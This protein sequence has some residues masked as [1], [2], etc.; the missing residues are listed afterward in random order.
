MK[1]T[2]KREETKHPLLTID[3][4]FTPVSG[5]DGDEFYPNGIFVFN[6]TKM[7]DYIRG[8]QAQIFS[9]SIDVRAHRSSFSHLNDDHIE[10]T[11]ISI[12]IILAE[13][14]PGRFNVIDGNHRI[15]KAYRSDVDT[16]LAYKL[17][18]DQHIR[19]LTTTEAYHAYV[20]YWNS[21]VNG[22]NPYRRKKVHHKL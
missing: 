6:I 14:S 19:F 7:I 4:N 1:R 13:I 16:I 9:E 17:R 5:D 12:P 2:L 3:N 11:D 10:K 15:E 18:P 20:E 22:E 8:H 21:K